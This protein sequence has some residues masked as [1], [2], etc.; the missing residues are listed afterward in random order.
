L[1]GIE[2]ELAPQ[3]VEAVKLPGSGIDTFPRLCYNMLA[4]PKGAQWEH[5]FV[6]K[7]R[8]ADR[9]G[10]LCLTRAPRGC[11]S[12]RMHRMHAGRVKAVRICAVQVG[13]GGVQ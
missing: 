1:P 10:L 3:G 13:E 7:A 9:G 4:G 2:A 6:D 12:C 5:F 8:L 11:Q